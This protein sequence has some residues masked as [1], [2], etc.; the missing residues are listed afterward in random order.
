MAISKFWLDVFWKMVGM[1]GV[2]VA[3][4]SLSTIK[5]GTIHSKFQLD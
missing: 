2:L 5:K 4:Q 3:F 1:E